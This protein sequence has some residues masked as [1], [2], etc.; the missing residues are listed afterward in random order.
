MIVYSEHV[1]KV[2]SNETNKYNLDRITE[3]KE[4]GLELTLL[5]QISRRIG[6]EIIPEKRPTFSSAKWSSC[7]LKWGHC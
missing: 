6:A 2:T 5:F 1:Q 4:N 3:M 7:R